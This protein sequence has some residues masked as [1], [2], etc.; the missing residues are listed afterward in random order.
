MTTWGWEDSVKELSAVPD[1]SPGAGDGW[2]L[3]V[4]HEK[5]WRDE[6]TCMPGFAEVPV[7]PFASSL[8][9]A[10]PPEDGDDDEDM[11]D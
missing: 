5:A 2:A 8:P 10:M 11:T 4:V 1:T 3:M 7:L 6:R 9:A